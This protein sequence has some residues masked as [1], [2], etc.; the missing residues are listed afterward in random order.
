M[1]NLP[2][3]YTQEELDSDLIDILSAKEE[4]DEDF[5]Y[6]RYYEINFI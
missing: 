4:V 2:P 6:D 3:G 5:E 1:D